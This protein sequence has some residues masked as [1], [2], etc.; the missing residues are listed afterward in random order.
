MKMK[1]LLEITKILL[2]KTIKTQL[3]TYYYYTTILYTSRNKR[4]GTQAKMGT[5]TRSLFYLIKNKKG[6]KSIKA[7]F[8]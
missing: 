5:F 8:I 3:G 4:F 6:V 7:N 2:I 1:P